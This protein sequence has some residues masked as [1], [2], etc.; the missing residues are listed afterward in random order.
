MMAGVT[1][2]RAFAHTQG[3]TAPVNNLRNAN[4]VFARLA[5]PLAAA[6]FC[7]PVHAQET[8]APAPEPAPSDI[9]T[10][11]VAAD[12]TVETPE[13]VPTI[14]VNVP[15]EEKP[16]QEPAA[17]SNRVLE[18][19]VVTAQK[20]KENVL[21]VPVSIQAFSAESLDARGITDQT[22]LQLATPGLDVGEQA[23]F[24]TIFLR[25]VGSDA[26]L[27]A[28]PSVAYYVDGIYFP[29]S[30]GQSQDFGAVDRV[31]VL[32]GP[33]GTLFG[34]NAVG[35][36]IS[37]I[38]RDPSFTDRSTSLEL[39]YGN[40]DTFDARVYTNLPLTDWLA[41]N[42]SAFYNNGDHYM[43]GL[44][45]GQ[46]LP[47]ERSRGAR[48]KVRIAPTENLDVVLTGMRLEQQG[49]GSVFTLNNSPTPAFTAGCA[50]PVP[51]P[52]CIEPQTGYEGELS[53]PTFLRFNTTVGYAQATYTMPW[54]DLK[55]LGS[56]QEARS[57]FTYDFDGSGQALAAFDQKRNFADVQTAEI[58]L[59]S[60]DTTWG[61]SRF[62]WI[63]GGYYFKSAQGFDTANLKLAGLDLADLQ[64]GGISLPP[65]LTDALDDL[66]IAFPNGDVAFHAIIGTR[67]TAVFAQ[68]TFTF[69]D[70]LALTLG[71]RYQDEERYLIR[72]DSGLYLSD[73]GFQTLFNWNEIGA[74]D[75]N[76]NFKDISDTTTSFKP[77]ATIELRPFDNDTLIY[78]SYQEA[79]KSATYNAVAIYQP[80]AFVEP[81]E[82]RAYE[83]GLKTRIFDGT[84]SVSIAAFDYDIKN[85][86]V[87]FISLF[88]GGAVSFENADAASIQ[89]LDLDVAVELFPSVFDGLVLTLGG[90]YLDAK[91]DR[92]VGAAGFDDEPSLLF[93]EGSG[94]FRDDNDYSGN[95]IVRTPKFTTTASVSKL[96][97]VPGGELELS[98]D[99]YCNDGFFYASSNSEELSQDSYRVFGARVSY[100]YARWGVRA[101]LFGR[102]LGDEKYSQGLIATDFGGNVTLAAPR[103]YGLRLNWDF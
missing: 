77:K 54:F 69:T 65:L 18:E 40:R 85:F 73:G 95:R 68:G 81:E 61:A 42:V 16:L 2:V 56:D 30:Q 39:G 8:Q 46:P 78:I 52:L 86:Q 64:R 7:A 103:T 89:G 97:Q 75:R 50:L 28:D 15:R 47:E 31:E 79:L 20:R 53:E 38:T 3:A 98:G 5:L 76:G 80:P 82:L 6:L 48:L 67:S 13:V 87:Q 21:D 24:T 92:Y 55:V 25:G 26:F 35:G 59:L 70:W 22:G 29:F 51:T 11:S 36:A 93:P 41:V 43:S 44:A 19:I 17:P 1:R 9:P 84:T 4:P 37:V 74:R 58:Q 10:A 23:Q 88:Q 94:L 101:T 60:N 102:N 34:R 72:S 27:M 49:T 100:L 33:Q 90:S 96:W 32:K 71:A 57:R 45:A 99:A 14:P 83:V 66:N 62:K 12:T 91:Y 63:V